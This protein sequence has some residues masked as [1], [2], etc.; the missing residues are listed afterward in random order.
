MA[1]HRAIIDL[2]EQ[3]MVDCM[4]ALINDTQGC[5]GG[6]IDSVAYYGVQF[7][8]ATE[9]FYPYRAVGGSCSQGRISEGGGFKINAYAYVMDCL[10]L[11]S[12]LLVTKPVSVC[13]TIDDQWQNYKS[14]VIPNC[15]GKSLG[16]HCVLLAG[17]SSDGTQTV[18]TN[19]WKYKNSW[20]V[21]Y[22]M[23]GYLQVYRDFTD[24]NGICGLCS[25]LYS[26]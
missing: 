11:A 15:N 19:F 18:A 9:K 17:V 4:T 10:Q 7:P 12:T 3:Q 13:G 16:G 20:G 24:L 2:S 8:I 26:I 1:K 22:G 14:G 23:N 6:Q 25:G 21:G 5:D